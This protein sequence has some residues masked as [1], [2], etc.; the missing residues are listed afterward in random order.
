MC[1]IILSII[2]IQMHERFRRTFIVLNIKAMSTEQNTIH[3]FDF[4]LICEYFSMFERQGP[5]SPEAT[6]KALSFVEELTADS[7]AADLGC[8]TGGQTMTL[9][10]QLPC[11]IT[12]LDLFPGFIERFK[13]NSV[14][15]GFQDR[16][17]GI[18]GSFADPLPFEKESL[19]LIWS[20]GA[21]YH[22]GFRKGIET[23]RPY[24]KTGGYIA[25]T[26]ASWLTNN[27]PDEIRNFWMEAYN[28]IDTIPTKIKQIQDAG[29]LP[30]ASFVLPDYCWIENFYLPQLQV[31][32][33]FLKKYPG[34][35][36]VER[37][38]EMER[39]EQDLFMKYREYY[40]YVFYIGRKL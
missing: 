32:E 25:L 7:S 30:V 16:V 10:G 12:G 33:E 3:E 20:E 40:G 6:L 28:E 34:N 27:R 4:N 29:Y 36:T 14:R 1:F 24:L 22:I 38:I 31:Q 8:G 9:A 17:K 15:L 26:E 13:Q 35:S 21:I 39:H 23:W 37:F 2:I 19:D 18:V 5:G 11:R